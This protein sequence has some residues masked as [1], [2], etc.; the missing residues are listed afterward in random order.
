[1]LTFFKITK[2]I[3][4]IK[5]FITNKKL[6]TSLYLKIYSYVFAPFFYPF[7]IIFFFLKI[8]LINI[9]WIDAIGHI[10]LEPDCFLREKSLNKKINYKGLILAPKN[11]IANKYFLNYL[12]KHFIVISSPILCFLLSP[13]KKI[14]YINHDISKYC[15]DIYST[16]KQYELIAKTYDKENFFNLTHI[17]QCIG[18][19]ILEKIGIKKNDWFV[20][21]HS[22]DPYYRNLGN[23]T[24]RDSNI[25]SYKKM[26]EYIISIGG[27]V[28]RMGSNKTEKLI[29]N[30]KNFIDYA[31]SNIRSEMMD[32][33]L[34]AKSKIF[35]GTNSGLNNLPLLFKTPILYLNLVPLSQLNSQP[36][37]LGVPKLLRKKKD[38]KF[39]KFN[40]AL[41]EPFGNSFFDKTFNDAGLEVIDNDSDLILDCTIEALQ[42]LNGSFVESQIDKNLQINFK[43][44]LKP[45]HYG[46]GTSGII[47][48]TFLRKYQ[49][50]F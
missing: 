6:K 15:M 38:G 11:K 16:A 48:T 40:E 1:M 20:T 45:G 30:N 24:V 33:F 44:L 14:N 13:L 29:I 28:L 3:K 9:I 25:E 31:N 7:G 42:R 23:Y 35:I 43:S 8:R 49:N 32:I 19:E 18:Y 27:F 10:C 39:L 46:Y 47:S 26:I 5:F 4:K 37:S 21:I 34:C 12:K 41:Q 2:L 36:N 50:L 17:D 22:R